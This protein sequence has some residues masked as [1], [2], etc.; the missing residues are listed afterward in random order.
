MKNLIPLLLVIILSSLYS[1][2]AQY[3]KKFDYQNNFQLELGG[4]GLIYSINYERIL[5]NSELL[6]TTGQIGIAYYPPFIGF[7]DV[8][9]P[10]GINEILSINNHHIEAGVGMV[11]I[12]E[13]SR[14]SGNTAIDWFWDGFLSARIGYRY[15]KPDGRFLFRAGFTPII[16]TN[17][18]SK[19]PREL[20]GK[21]LSEV[22]PLAAVSIGYNF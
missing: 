3:S 17:I 21:F 12:R 20:S 16:E 13:A 1:A 18:F 14:D 7:R 10:I 2:Q 11:I 9:I 6:K 22:H 8:W 4:H 19:L 15:Q 5:I